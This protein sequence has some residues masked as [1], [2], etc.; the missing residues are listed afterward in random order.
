M[1]DRHRYLQQEQTEAEVAEVIAEVPV[2]SEGLKAEKPQ[3]PPVCH[4]QAS[5]R[6]ETASRPGTSLEDCEKCRPSSSGLSSQGL[7]K[8]LEMKKRREKMA[9]A[10]QARQL[11][12]EAALEHQQ[13]REA[14]A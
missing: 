10:N 13:R 1:Q 5:T 11:C 3:P 2:S 9:Q 14:N 8:C 4:S 6:A 7:Q 12:R